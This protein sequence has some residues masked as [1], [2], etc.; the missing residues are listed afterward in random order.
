MAYDPKK[1]VASML[2]QAKRKS[3]KASPNAITKKIYLEAQ[4]R[5]MDKN[6]TAPELAFEV[7]MKSLN[8]EYTSQKIVGGKIYDFFLE[9]YN[10][11][12]EVD[13]DYFHANP[14]KYKPEDLNEMQKKSI[15]TDKRK[16]IIAKGSGYGL[17]R[18]WESDILKNPNFVRDI[19]IKFINYHS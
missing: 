4:A 19:L 3:R 18:F 15:K 13:G 9:K 16:D 12:I 14:E 17:L 11:L 5:K 10:V 2:R 8:I 6:P 1:K 7:M